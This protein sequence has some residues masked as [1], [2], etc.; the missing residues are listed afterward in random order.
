MIRLN[1][2]SKYFPGAWL[3]GENALCLVNAEARS[4][5]QNLE[6]RPVPTHCSN[7]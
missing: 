4:P 6:E 5:L 2:F 1:E 3:M 7:E